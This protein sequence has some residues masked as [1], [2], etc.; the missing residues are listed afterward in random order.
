M[1]NRPVLTGKPWER[2]VPH[3]PANIANPPLLFTS[4]LTA[5]APDGS[6]VGAGDMRRQAEQVL[7]NC[8][9][10][11]HAGGSDTSRI[12]KLSIFVTSIADFMACRDCLN[13]L[14]V[15][16]PSSTLV[17]VSALQEAGMAIEIEAIAEIA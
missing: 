1:G 6:L 11:L 9:D 12:V 4:G 15:S 5:R 14:F 17:Q 2:R 3:A 8:K 10:V 7:A 13:E 16:A